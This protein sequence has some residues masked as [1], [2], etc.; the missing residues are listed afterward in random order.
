MSNAKITLKMGQVW[1]EDL[2]KVKRQGQKFTTEWI[3]NVLLYL[4]NLQKEL[5]GG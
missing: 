3:N 4:Q 5:Q 1:F 2:E